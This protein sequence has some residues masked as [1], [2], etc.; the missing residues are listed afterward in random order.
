[1]N[2][3]YWSWV[4]RPD[5]LAAA[6]AV[7]VLAA[8]AASSLVRDL[9]AADR[10]ARWRRLLSASLALG[11]GAFAAHII[12]MS[13]EALPGASGHDSAALL[14]AFGLIVACS[15][16]AQAAVAGPAVSPGRLFGAA[17]V[18]GA[19]LCAGTAQALR[20]LQHEHAIVWSV[21]GLAAAW[22]LGSLGAGVAFALG[23][24]SR[25]VRGARLGRHASWPAALVMGAT[26]VAVEVAVICSASVPAL[27]GAEPGS[28]NGHEGLT[29]L[30]MLGA[31]A[32]LV[33]LL[34]SSHLEVRF[35]DLLA[36]ARDELKRAGHTDPLTSLP[37][38]Q[39]FEERLQR[40][41]HRADHSAQRLALL[42][43]NLDG[44]KGVNEAFGQGAGD[45]LL[46]TIGQRLREFCGHALLARAG[47]DEFLIL[48][49]DDPDAAA[50]ARRTAAVLDE[51]GRPCDIGP[52]EVTVSGSIGIALY[53]EHGALSRLIPHAAAA[54]HAAKHMG[55]AT[56]CFFEAQ[57][58]AGK[59]EEVEL[60]RDLRSAIEQRE[61]ELVYQ[62]KIHAPSGQITGAEALMRWHHPQR[63]IVSPLVFIPLAEHYG[64]INALGNW[65]IDDACRQI[66]A[67]RNLGLRMRVAINLSVNQL[68]QADLAARIDAALRR[69]RLEPRV[70]TCEITESIAMDD[71]PA[72]LDVIQQL[73]AVG[74]H[75]SIDDFGTGYS[76]LSCLRKLPA[77][78][79]KIDRSFVQDLA[80]SADARA[81]VDA[82][83]KLAQAIG[84]KVV[85][86]GV[87][88]EEQQEILR[89]LGCHEL[90][91]YLFA[92]PMSARALARWAMTHEGPRALDFRASLFGETCAVEL[93]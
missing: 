51:I 73:A 6:G 66:R 13:G 85:A 90:Q 57:M 2:P 30:A 71:S 63:G 78:E 42:F 40:A 87:E 3:P 29:L 38:R 10:G 37:N 45:A 83:V 79:L 80:T 77:E 1:M 44:L 31:P 17:L 70:L 36:L 18:F 53:P 89:Q 64:L 91:G 25:P 74:V 59:R 81:I 33:L 22:L 4:L 8:F 76:N 23:S 75:L 58:V 48:F 92:K 39:L 88:T 50:V 5:L 15:L 35:R 9:A 12:V 27:A 20:A 19:G 34:M 52:S 93:S 21:A 49:D 65:V 61:L 54:L 24:L 32:V 41:V 56:Y 60:L 55:G 69:H 43:I 16:A 86:E 26:V 67:W 28:P 84:L 82:V 62:P 68:R 7:G 47:G 11:S 72:T 14:A 46:R